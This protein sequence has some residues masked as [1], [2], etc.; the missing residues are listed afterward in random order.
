MSVELKVSIKKQTEYQNVPPMG[1][2][3][4]TGDV[5][6]KISDNSREYCDLDL[7]SN[8][9]EATDQLNAKTLVTFLGIAK[10]TIEQE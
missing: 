3:E 6:L 5:Y 4:Y 8:A 9:L 2:F 1:L 10:V 7:Q